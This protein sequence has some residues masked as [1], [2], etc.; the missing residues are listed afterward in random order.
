MREGYICVN[1]DMSEILGRNLWKHHPPLSLHWKGWIDVIYH[2]S[3]NLQE[4]SNSS[5]NIPCSVSF[6]PCTSWLCGNIVGAGSSSGRTCAY[7]P[8]TIKTV[9]PWSHMVTWSQRPESSTQERSKN[10]R[11]L[12][13]WPFDV[14]KV[15]FKVVESCFF[16][17]I[18]TYFGR[19]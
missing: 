18:V 10:K 19:F 17:E 12:L 5:S 11:L 1:R 3:T 15:C 13:S 14:S 4:V 9:W 16:A 6:E 2:T 7:L 8:S